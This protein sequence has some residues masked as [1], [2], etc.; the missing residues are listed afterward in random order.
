MPDESFTFSYDEKHG[1]EMDF[2]RRL[3]RKVE[4]GKKASL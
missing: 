3:L 4:G 2:G 1:I